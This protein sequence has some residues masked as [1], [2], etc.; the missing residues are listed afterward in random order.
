MTLGGRIRELRRKAGLTQSEL[1]ERIGYSTKASISKIESDVL[2]V[3]QSTIVALAKALGVTPSTLMGWDDEENNPEKSNIAYVIKDGIYNIPLYESVSAGFGA[4]AQDCII[5]YIH[6]DIR[7]P[8]EAK[9][10]IAI[11]VAGDSMYPKIEDGDTIVI[12]K[13][14]SVDSGQ[15][16]VVLIDGEDAV[17]K[18]V[19]YDKSWV[20]LISINPEYKTRHFEKEEVNRLRVLGLV[21]QIIKTV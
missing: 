10:T 8:Y 7:N 19:K 18:K 14:D 20:D 13:Q 12:H 4:T 16:A 3:N 17:V 9:E 1:A 6:K 15:I 11:K 2:D 5:D 21:K